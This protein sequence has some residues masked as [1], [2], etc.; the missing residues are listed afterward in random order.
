[1][2]HQILCKSPVMRIYEGK[3]HQLTHQT[4]T[5]S[6]HTRGNYRAP[7]R[8]LATLK[9]SPP[10][11]LSFSKPHPEYQT[12]ISKT[13]IQEMT[14]EGIN[15]SEPS[16]PSTSDHKVNRHLKWPN[17]ILC[18]EA[19]LVSR[20]SKI[21]QMEVWRKV[22]VPGLP[23]RLSTKSIRLFNLSQSSHN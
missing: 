15:R 18:I 1:M 21:S 3:I 16:F 13:E 9:Y 5:K 10:R 17:K 12:Q 22:L 4:I 23:G 11:N 6:L 20:I 14:E 2:V 19:L 7:S 8:N